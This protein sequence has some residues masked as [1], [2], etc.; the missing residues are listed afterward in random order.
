MKFVVKT[1]IILLSVLFM[2]SACRRTAKEGSEQSSGQEQIAKED[3]EKN[4]KDIANPLPEPFQISGMLEDIGASY[5]GKILNAPENADGYYTQKSKS[6][7]IGVYAADLA[8]AT[9][10]NKQE[11][12][13]TYSKVLK[14]ILDDLSVGVNYAVLQDEATRQKLADKDSLVDFISNIYFDTYQFL[15]K[16]STPSLAALMA[17]GAWIEGLFIA[18]HISDDTYQ[19]YEIVKII[20][21]QKESLDDLINLMEKFKSDE[22]VSSLQDALKKLKVLYDATEGSLT[23]KQLD[24]IVTTIETIRDSIIS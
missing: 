6:V 5:L 16:E 7:N 21:D 14:S 13:K 15:C 12:I 23:E 17:A 19:N 22:M 1:L 4:L 24:T 11:D 2:I 9:T 18:T 20:Y 3:I 8:Y 10:Y